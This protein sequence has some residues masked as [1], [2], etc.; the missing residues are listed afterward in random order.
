[1]S[2][3]RLRQQFLYLQFLVHILFA[4]LIYGFSLEGSSALF[5]FICLWFLCSF[6]VQLIREVRYARDF[7]PFHILM[8]A[9]LQFVG[10]N[11]LSLWGRQ[12]A[13]EI[14]LFGATPVN[15]A[16]V[17]GVFYLSLQHILV[18]I[19]FHL[20]EKRRSHD[21]T[22][23]TSL[24]ERIKKSQCNY[25]S[26]A[27][28]AYTLVWLLRI[29]NTFMPLG[30]V[31]SV[32]LQFTDMGQVVV[33]LLILFASIQ[34]RRSV[35]KLHW[36][37]VAIE[38]ALALG[39]GMK[40]NIIR[41][42][43]PYA[44]YLFILYKE[45][46]ISVRFPLIAKLAILSIFVLLVFS[47]ISVFR[48]IVTRT[49]KEWSQITVAETIQEF[50]EYMWDEGRYSR[51]RT[52]QQTSVDY[53]SSRAGAITCTAW[54]IDYA[55]KKGAQPD[56]MYYCAVGILPRFFF[57]NKPP[58][59]V[60]GMIFHLSMGD[61]NAL[62]KYREHT[63]SSSSIGLIGSCYFAL[64]FLGAIIIPLFLGFFCSLYWLVIK[65]FITRDIVAIWAFFLLISVYL[66][67]YEAF[68]DCGIV[69]VAW[70]CVYMLVIYLLS[71][72]RRPDKS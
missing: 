52:D 53:L 34:R 24:Y 5:L 42:I 20:I 51:T 62:G 2:I 46:V 59:Q 12:S 4:V 58:L 37:V 68:Q 39:D 7:H 48:G 69:F 67:D 23:N 1:M 19:G 25:L 22:Y 29:I 50:G 44:I 31:S 38:V 60:G 64:G 65:K 17:L 55:I 33:L 28:G 35:F 11:G 63:Q 18:F 47:Y 71:L 66:K 15:E 9:S 49:Q 36:V 32:L 56:Y 45:G 54:A 70:S 8:L 3:I 6:T 21:E 41:N 30:T 16:L 61:E 13:G 26:W 27:V 10:V 57:P 40:E 72:A 43:I 14:I